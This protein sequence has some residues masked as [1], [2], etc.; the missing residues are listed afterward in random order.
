[1]RVNVAG[2]LKALRMDF[3]DVFV[4]ADD[5]YHIKQRMTSFGDTGARSASAISWAFWLML[6]FLARIVRNAS[7]RLFWRP[8]VRPD[9][10]HALLAG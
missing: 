3:D 7:P 1:M 5:V 2:I 4:R 9:E 10:D 8:W 6:P